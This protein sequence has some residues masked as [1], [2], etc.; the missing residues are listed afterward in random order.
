MAQWPKKKLLLL[1]PSALPA[2]NTC[3]HHNTPVNRHCPWDEG[4]WACCYPNGQTLRQ[5]FPLSQSLNISQGHRPRATTRGGP[6]WKEPCFRPRRT[7][8][9]HSFLGQEWFSLYCITFP[10][11]RPLVSLARGFT[12][13]RLSITSLERTPQTVGALGWGRVGSLPLILYRLCWVP[14][15]AWRCWE[16]V[17]P[18]VEDGKDSLSEVEAV[19]MLET[20]PSGHGWMWPTATRQRFYFALIV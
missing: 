14:S 2:V 8:M 16:M 20:L 13:T 1:S 3:P 15:V 19:L 7:W 18:S 11:P 9:S 6:T 10:P 17:T 12:Q 5:I 4:L